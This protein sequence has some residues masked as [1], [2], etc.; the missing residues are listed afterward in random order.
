MKP[1]KQKAQGQKDFALFLVLA[2]SFLHAEY[3]EIVDST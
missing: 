3:A 2:R 1:T